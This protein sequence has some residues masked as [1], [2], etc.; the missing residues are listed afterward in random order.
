MPGFLVP[1]QQTLNA[2]TPTATISSTTVADALIEIDK[3]SIHVFND[4][5]SRSTTIPTPTEGMVTYLKSLKTLNVYNGTA[6]IEVSGSGGNL[7][8]LAG[9]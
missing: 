8:F 1:A 3:E 6:W 4:A 5:A 2:F 7:V 9:T